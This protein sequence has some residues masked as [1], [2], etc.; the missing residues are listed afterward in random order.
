MVRTLGFDYKSLPR[1]TSSNLVLASF[2]FFVLVHSS[3]ADFRSVLV[4]LVSKMNDTS[5]SS[6]SALPNHP[7]YLTKALIF[8][9]IKGHVQ[10]STVISLSNNVRIHGLDMLLT[11]AELRLH[12]SLTSFKGP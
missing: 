12:F 2:F 3:V 10:P 1:S 4:F 11:S 7:T 6:L 9:L 8:C 5:I